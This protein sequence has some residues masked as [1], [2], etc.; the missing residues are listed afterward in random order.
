MV[1]PGGYQWWRLI[2]INPSIGSWWIHKLNPSGSKWW[3]QV[4]S[5]KWIPADPHSARWMMWLIPMVDS[6]GSRLWIQVYP[7]CGSWWILVDSTDGSS[8][9][10]VDPCGGSWWIHVVDPG[11]SMWWI[12][13]MENIVSKLN[14]RK[15]STWLSHRLNARNNYWC[16]VQTY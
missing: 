6:G 5:T 13:H 2:K 12:Y 1:D 15:K 11:G 3:I 9:I 14:F 10:L 16:S 7:S 8:E 4:W